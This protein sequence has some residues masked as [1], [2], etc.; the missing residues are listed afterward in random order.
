MNMGQ[1]RRGDG[2]AGQGDEFYNELIATHE[3]L[4]DDDS[5][6]LNARLVLLLANHVADLA[7]VREALS[8]AR[9]SLDID[10]RTQR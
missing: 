8:A 6:K 10:K 1:L 4:S 2:F 5:A 7:V 3:G 9:A